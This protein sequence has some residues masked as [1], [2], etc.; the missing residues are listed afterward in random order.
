MQTDGG[1]RRPAAR[2]VEGATWQGKVANAGEIVAALQRLWRRFGATVPTEIA[3]ADG[4]IEDER[5]V[6]GV[7]LRASTL[8]LIAVA[9]TRAAAERIEAA[10]TRL[11]DLSPSRVTILVADPGLDTGI[12]PGLS[13]RVALL[14]QEADRGRPAIRYEAVVVEVGA[15]N[16]RHL[17]SLVSPLLVAD[18]PDVRWWA[19]PAVLGSELFE[20]PRP[21][22]VPS[23]AISPPCSSARRAAPN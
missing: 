20:P 3:A 8:N 22:P 17:A 19:R 18:L 23:C 15:S 12:E 10:V 1:I 6:V 11:S 21:T 13:A 5:Q 2:P 4:A 16:E 7:L 14:E 9:P